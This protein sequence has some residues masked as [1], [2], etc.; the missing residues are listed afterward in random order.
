VQTESIPLVF[1]ICARATVKEQGTCCR[2]LG[3]F[4][5]PSEEGLDALKD[6]YSSVHACQPKIQFFGF[7]SRRAN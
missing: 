1:G 7:F 5:E 4:L 2:H 6:I 3:I